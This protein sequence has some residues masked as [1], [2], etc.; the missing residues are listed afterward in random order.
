MQKKGV[1]EGNALVAFVLPLI[2]KEYEIE[3][4]TN[5]SNEVI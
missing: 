5:Q 2:K 3:S 1:I 4:K